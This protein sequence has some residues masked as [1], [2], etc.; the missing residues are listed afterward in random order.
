MFS[1]WQ[2]LHFLAPPDMQDTICAQ[3]LFVHLACRQES[4]S[5]SNFTTINE[6]RGVYQ[7][8]SRGKKWALKVG[9]N[10]TLRE[11][12]I[13]KEA[14]LLNWVYGDEVENASYS[15]NCNDTEWLAL[16]TEW[17]EPTSQVTPSNIRSLQERQSRRLTDFSL[18]GVVSDDWDFCHLL[19]LA[20][21]AA[22]TLGT[23]QELKP[24]IVDSSLA[25]L[26]ELQCEAVDFPLVLCHGDLGPGNILAKQGA[27]VAIDWE[28]AFWGI[29]NFDYLYWLTFLENSHLISEANLEEGDLSLPSQLRIILAIVVLKSYLIRNT[30]PSSMRTIDFNSRVGSILKMLSDVR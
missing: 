29:P 21:T 20:V 18:P 5:I 23:E 28:D 16:Q 7:F 13:R 24:V 12:H 26:Q 10:S 14:S 1:K 11:S 4:S 30:V 25:H 15:F 8:A 3:D 27:L 22:E 2:S 6:A 17:L 19:G 9:A